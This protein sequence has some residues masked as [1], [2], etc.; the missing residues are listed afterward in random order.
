MPENFFSA[1]Y[2]VV[3]EIFCKAKMRQNYY[4]LGLYPGPQ[5]GIL[6]P[7]RRLPSRLVREYCTPSRFYTILDAC[8][9]LFSLRLHSNIDDGSTLQEIELVEFGL[10]SGPF[11]R[12]LREEL[13]GLL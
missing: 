12:Q 5:R 6:R 2:A 10:C 11:L 8:G 9:V 7:S 4:R 13:V 1:R 3:P